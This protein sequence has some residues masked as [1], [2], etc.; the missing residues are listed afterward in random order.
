[1][2]ANADTLLL[3]LRTQFLGG[4]DL[5]DVLLDNVY[6]KVYIVLLKLQ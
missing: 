1:M 2:A 3:G 6:L 5:K 4:S